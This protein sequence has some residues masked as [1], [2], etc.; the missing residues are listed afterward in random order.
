[1]I[2]KLRLRFIMVALTSVFVTLTVIMGLINGLNYH[3]ILEESDEMLEILSEN[4][5]V[6]SSFRPK[7][8]KEWNPEAPFDTRFFMVAL[9]TNNEVSAIQMARIAAIDE[10]QA[11]VYAKQVRQENKEHGFIGHYRYTIEDDDEKATIYFLDCHRSLDS[12]YTFLKAS[13]LVSVVGFLVVSGLIIFFSSRIMAPVIESYMKQKRFITDAGHELRTPLATIQAD[14]DVLSLDGENE[15]IC[16]IQNQVQKLTRL[17]DELI[18]MAKMDELSDQKDFSS[19]SISSLIQ[20]CV[21]SFLS[22][23]K[24]NHKKL[25]ISIEPDINYN[26]NR[27]QIE[28]VLDALLDNAIKY[29]P[30]NSQID[31]RL[32]KNKKNVIIE[33]E[34]E[35]NQ[36]KE[37]DL[38][39][40]FDRFYRVDSSRNTKTG[41]YGIGL[42]MVQSVIENHGGY[43]ETTLKEK[44]FKI[45]IR[46]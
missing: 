19:F 28:K 14:A 18:E 29:A 17:T 36:M 9:D 6:L 35:A 40:L 12:F 42:S 32:F 24:A 3:N 10:E 44:R 4:D 46:L 27:N 33:F 16:D 2:K 15:W 21:D 43:I 34:N 8:S 45:S 39:H 1:M 20:E 26:G 23:A 25:N 13:C 37:N 41:G 22:K 11:I 5:G 31:I 30:Q 7:T 38:N